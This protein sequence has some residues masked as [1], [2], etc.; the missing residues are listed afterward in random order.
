MR[1]FMKTNEVNLTGSYL[2]PLYIAILIVAFCTLMI[3][4]FKIITAQSNEIVI[5]VGGIG[6]VSAIAGM[7]VS[8]NALRAENFL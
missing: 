5:I 8:I 6:I 4:V 7:L 3:C 1:I 2:V